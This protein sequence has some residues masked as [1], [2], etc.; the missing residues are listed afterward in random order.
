MRKKLIGFGLLA[1][2]IFSLVLQGVAAY[3]GT[4][5]PSPV[6]LAQVSYY[7]PLS[8]EEANSLL[9]MIEE[10]KLARDVYLKLYNETGLIIFDRIAQSEQRHMDAVLM[11]IEKYN[12]T[13]PDTLNE[14][15]VFENEELQNLYNELVEMGSQSV[16]DALKVGALIEEIDIKDLEEWLSKVDNED[17]KVVFENLMDGSKNHL[18]AFTKVLAD[19]YG[20]EY[21]P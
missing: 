19:N 15:G 1:L 4:P 5:G 12:L 14:I 18:R 9:Y 13:A 3:R 7:A 11:L 16:V 8:D 2:G 21:T 6:A 10:E 17:I 20:I